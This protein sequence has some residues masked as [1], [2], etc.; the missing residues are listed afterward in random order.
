MFAVGAGTG[1]KEGRL[2]QSMGCQEGSREPGSGSLLALFGGLPRYA[3]GDSTLGGEVLSVRDAGLAYGEGLINGFVKLLLSLSKDVC[4]RSASTK[5]HLGGSIHVSSL[6]LQVW[7][8]LV[9]RG[10][11]DVAGL[12]GGTVFQ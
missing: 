10:V 12:R 7:R 3:G 1:P 5:S 2:G 6:F 8:V 9:G 4:V 11:F